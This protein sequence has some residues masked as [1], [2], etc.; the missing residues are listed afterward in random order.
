VAE[1]KKPKEPQAPKAH[2]EPEEHGRLLFGTLI[3][4]TVVSGLVDAVSYLGLGHVFTAN[5]TGNVVVLGFAAAGA[6][7]FSAPAC[8]TSLGAF[9]LGAAAAGSAARRLSSRRHLL[10]LAMTV[11]ALATGICAAIG[12]GVA[13]VSGGWPRFTIIAVLAVGMGVRNSTIRRLAVPDLTT[14]VLTMTLTGLAAD[15]SLAGGTNPHAGRRIAA[16]A[17]MLAGALAGATAFLH[18]GAGPTLLAGSVLVLIGG[19]LYWSTQE[20]RQLDNPAG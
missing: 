17:A 4:L 7:G 11:E 20:S 18:V 14:T 19:L 5:M 3:G 13:T 10:L 16:V 15:S 9:L 2:K 12:F 1:P 8:L 6:K